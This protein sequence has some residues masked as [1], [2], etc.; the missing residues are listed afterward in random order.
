MIYVVVGNASQ[1]IDKEIAATS[2][3]Q[4]IYEGDLLPR[5]EDPG[6]HAMGVKAPGGTVIR[7]SLDGEKIE[8]VAGGLR[9][10]YDLVFDE[11]GDLFVH[12]SDMEADEGMTWYRPTTVFHIAS[13]SELGWR[14]GWSK[15]PFHWLDQTPPVCK[16][17]RGSP[18]GA[19]LYQHLQFPVR[20]QDTIFLADWSEGRILALK[21]Q[22]SGS[23]YVAKAEEFLTGKPL[24]VTDLAVGEDG[25]LYFSTGGR[26]TSGGVYRIA[27]RGEIP[28]NMLNFENKLTQVIRHPQPQSPWARQNIAN[29]RNEMG[30][31]WNDLCRRRQRKPGH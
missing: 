13:G 16:T 10:V 22:R 31:N 17:G 25:G 12:D 3:Y 4:N 18:A 2:P 11:Q 8:T 20:Y 21:K 1:V 29:L 19:V 7:V 30:S 14:S 27:W 28:S 15:F 26:G 24:N 23:S 9:N 5:Y 6:G